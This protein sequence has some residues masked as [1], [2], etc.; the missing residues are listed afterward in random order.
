MEKEKATFDEARIQG[1]KLP[2]TKKDKLFNKRI[3]L[4][5]CVKG[6]RAVRTKGKKLKGK[7][8]Q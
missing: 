7:I 2:L 3:K 5:E 1:K 8:L 6:N 4:Q